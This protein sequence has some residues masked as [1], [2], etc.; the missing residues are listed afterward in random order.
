MS[1][2]DDL[3]FQLAKLLSRELHGEL[4]KLLDYFGDPPNL[5]KVPNS[6]WETDWKLIAKQVEPALVEFFIQQAHDA[7]DG[8]GVSVD[9]PAGNTDAAEWAR[10]YGDEIIVRVYGE[11]YKGASELIA[12][13]YLNG[14]TTRELTK[15]IETNYSCSHEIGET[16][17][18]TELTRAQ[19]EGEKAMARRYFEMFGSSLVP[20][21]KTVTDEHV[22][23]V[24]GPRNE[25]PIIDDFYLPAH[26]RCRCRLS[27]LPEP[28][29][30]PEQ[31]KK[32]NN[33][34]Q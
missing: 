1:T 8:I 6:Y 14:W 15:K 28:N 30:I 22:C 23:L 32:W 5:S 21:W 9:L 20:I 7:L 12:Q 3:E 2:R 19:V 11:A 31:L 16:I 26:P 10:Q 13:A 34:P 33:R 27:F 25:L 24:C 18:T 17:A 4:K 29:L